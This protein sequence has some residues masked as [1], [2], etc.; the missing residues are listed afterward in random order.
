[1]NTFHFFVSGVTISAADAAAITTKVINFYKNTATPGNALTNTISSL[2][3]RGTNA[4]EVRVYNLSHPMPRQ[5][6]SSTFF[7]I[8]GSTSTVS[9]PAEV[10]VVLSLRA[11]VPLGGIPARYRGRIYLGPLNINASGGDVDGDIRVA[12]SF[13]Q[14]IAAAAVNMM[15]QPADL[16]AW[17]VFSVVDQAARR[18]TRAC[19]DNSFDTQRRRGGR[20]TTRFCSDLPAV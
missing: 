20:P 4:H 7:T 9:Y 13:Q 17:S 18:I 19:V 5:P 8:L 2:I 3:S 16:I 15:A 10:A 1:V 14:Q 12:G 11:P 6:V